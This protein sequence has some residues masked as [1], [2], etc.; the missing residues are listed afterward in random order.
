MPFS[1]EILPALLALNHLAQRP[2][3]DHDAHDLVEH[4]RRRHGGEL[5]IGVVRGLL[6]RQPSVPKSG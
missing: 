6:S 3:L 2:V 4:I 1:L 5:G